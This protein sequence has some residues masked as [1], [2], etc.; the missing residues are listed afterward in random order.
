MLDM[1]CL[2]ASGKITELW[3]DDKYTEDKVIQAWK[4]ITSR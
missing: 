4:N 1:H 3:Y 2:E